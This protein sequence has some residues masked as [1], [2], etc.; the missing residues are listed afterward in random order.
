MSHYRHEVPTHID[1][2][3]QVIYGLTSR[4]LMTAVVGCALIAALIV[5]APL[6]PAARLGVAG[7]LGL[8]VVVFVLWRPGQ[9]SCGDWLLVAARY[10]ARPRVAVWRRAVLPAPA[11]REVR[12][13][14]LRTPK[15]IS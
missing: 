1:V 7:A 2:N 11:A 3:E 6:P 9:R 8:V 10:H 15:G 13:V 4:Q 14:V 12:E 5:H